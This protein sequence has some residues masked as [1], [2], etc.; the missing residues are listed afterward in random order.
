MPECLRVASLGGAES[1]MLSAGGA[2]SLMLSV[3]STE[4]MDTLSVR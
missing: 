2:V 3:G 4:S 1:I